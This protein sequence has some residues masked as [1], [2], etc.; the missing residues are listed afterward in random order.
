M[1]LMRRAVSD[2]RRR[3][4]GFVESAKAGFGMG[5]LSGAVAGGLGGLD[6]ISR[7]NNNMAL[8][9]EQLR[10]FQGYPYAIIR[11]IANRIAGQPLR[12]A[13]VIP[14]GE[15]NKS[16][17]GRKRL[18]RK[19]R[20]FSLTHSK[21][22]PRTLKDQVER[23]ELLEDHKLLELFRNP[24]PLMVSYT[25]MYVTI[26]ALELT[27]RGYWWFH[28]EEDGRMR[29]WP[30]PPSWVEPEHTELQLYANWKVRPSGFGETFVV[31]G[32]EMAYFYYPD[33]ANPLGAI[34]PLQAMAK[35]VVADENI[36]ESQRRAFINGLNP[37]LA[38][39]VG[40]WPEA[41]AAGITTQAVLTK[42][43]RNVIINA[44][45]QQ[46]R[47]VV[48]NE[49]PLI[50]DGLIKDVKKITQAPREMDFL[51]SSTATKGRLSQGWGVNPTS[52]GEIEGANRSIS[53]TADQHLADNVIN[54][55]LEMFS[56]IL[57]TFLAPRLAND[58]ERIV[59]YIET[60]HAIDPDYDL[61]VETAMVDRGAMSRNEWRHAHGKA[62]IKDGNS[63]FVGGMEIPIETE[64]S[65]DGKSSG[66][67]PR[68]PL[69]TAKRGV[70][71]A[72]QL[73]QAGQ[74]RVWTKTHGD[75]EIDYQRALRKAFVGLGRRLTETL[76]DAVGEH[77][78]PTAGVLEQ[79]FH[80]SEWAEDLRAVAE[81]HIEQAAMTGAI[82]EWELHKGGAH[83]RGAKG[84]RLRVT[85]DDLPKSV[86]TQVRNLVAELLDAPSWREVVPA[87][88]EALYRAINQQ[89]KSGKRGRELARAAVNAVLGVNAASRRA[90]ATARTDT[91]SAVNGGQHFTRQVLAKRGIIRGKVWV[92]K[93]DDVTRHTHYEAN[94]QE[95]DPS[96]EFTL[97]GFQCSYP[98]D[99]R[100]PIGERINCRCSVQSKRG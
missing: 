18:R 59:V 90:A 87:M 5:G 75:L 73:G 2:A 1:S 65:Y 41:A 49:E 61:A 35:T 72:D 16:F 53:A 88:R 85:M 69:P 17:A 66:A 70:C 56:Q 48:N 38:V 8:H 32:D 83:H 95:V 94:G 63:S 74:L 11:L 27:G 99:P 47:G 37:G 93:L 82:L 96:A 10:H 86:R 45:K 22:V 34:S 84:D 51:N 76:S 29:I 60:A 21:R 57:T 9:S 91:T 89:A 62:P 12:V 40:Q 43:Q 25:L 78:E 36:E 68:R 14:P 44:L 58:K 15:E 20:E 50:L 6:S 52:M 31:P 42:D 71:L 54:P 97:G 23:A 39:I 77:G 64:D 7:N 30:L 80:D 13:R 81:P 55:R 33:P 67:K 3:S 92:A 46:Y 79:C 98:G 4:L 28:E 26:A 19:M 24:N 100:L